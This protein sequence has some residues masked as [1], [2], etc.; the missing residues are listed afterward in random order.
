LTIYGDGRQVRDVLCVDDLVSA[1]DAVRVHLPTTAGQIYNI[2]G[3]PANTISLLELIHVIEEL[4][5]TRVE[6]DMAPARP[7]DQLVYVT[8]FSK[9]RRDTGWEPR[10]DIRETLQ[11]IYK[12]WKSNR[13]LFE[14]VPQP[15]RVPAGLEQL[16]EAA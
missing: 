1:F 13:D 6:Y 10:L 12:W 11:S 16:P 9:L 7:G 3:G 14:S 4:I 8:D 2:G 15:E 5:G